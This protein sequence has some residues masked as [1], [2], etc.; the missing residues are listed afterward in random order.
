[1]SP[2]LNDAKERS[3]CII[4]AYQHKE[5]LFFTDPIIYMV[6]YDFGSRYPA[7]T[8]AHDKLSLASY[9][10]AAQTVPIHARIVLPDPCAYV[11]IYIHVH[12][13]FLLYA[14]SIPFFA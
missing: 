10:Q 4:L 7:C 14:V 8:V 2:P 6:A 9:K 5:S 11:H 12:I 1:M 13:C 3:I